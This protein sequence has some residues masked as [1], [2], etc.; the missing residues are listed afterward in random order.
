MKL[1]GET[2]KH[3]LGCKHPIRKI[4]KKHTRNMRGEES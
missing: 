1:T 4:K 3:T 2:P